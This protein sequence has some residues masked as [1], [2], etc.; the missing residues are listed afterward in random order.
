M[1]GKQHTLIGIAGL[2]AAVYLHYVPAD[3]LWT[4]GLSAGACVIGALLPD[5]DHN[6]STIR[7][8]TGTARG[9]G[10]LGW[11]GGIL[12]A[13]LGG[14]RGFTHTL[15][16]AA[17][18]AWLAFRFLPDRYALA[19]TVGYGTHLLGDMVTANGIPLLW[20]IWSKRIGGVK[21]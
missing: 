19:F 8:S 7:H 14:H 5:I 11:L 9:N 13:A 12:S 21:W 4:L 17:L 3:P 2:G 15:L 6:E 18:L 1:N 16:C 20:P 10:P